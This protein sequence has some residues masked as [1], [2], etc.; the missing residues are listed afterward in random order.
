[1]WRWGIISH[2][3]EDTTI[4]N[5]LKT[6]QEHYLHKDFNEALK[7]LENNKSGIDPITWHYNM[8][9]LSAEMNQWAEARFHIL[10]A[11]KLGMRS[12]FLDQNKKLIETKLDVQRLE[13]PLT[14]TDYFIKVGLIGAQGPLMT[15][16]LIS[17]IFCLIWIRKAKKISS[18]LVSVGLVLL[19]LLL[20]WWISSW[21][22]KMVMQKKAIYDGPSTIFTTNSEIPSGV[23]L[24]TSKKGIWEKIIY[25]SRFEGWIKSDGLKR[26]ETK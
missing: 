25:P 23:V 1:M 3:S 22:F 8:A 10:L 21:P 17:L 19:P 20:S 16:A 13:S 6:F 24:I 2:V 12:A 14:A 11:E 9:T 7:V 18:A 26:L 15:L 4:E 5:A